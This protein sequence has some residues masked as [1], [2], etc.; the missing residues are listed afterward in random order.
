MRSVHIV[1]LIFYFVKGV[2]YYFVAA[3]FSL[4]MKIS[5]VGI[6]NNAHP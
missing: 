1:L 2:Y 5:G 3:G 6:F 4:R